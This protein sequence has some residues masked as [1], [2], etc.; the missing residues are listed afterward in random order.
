MSNSE[1]VLETKECFRTNS[2]IHPLVGFLCRFG[3]V[4]GRSDLK[5]MACPP[6]SPLPPSGIHNRSSP[7]DLLR[8]HHFNLARQLRPSL[9]P[10]CNWLG[11]DDVR[12]VGGQPFSAGGFS[13]LW[14][15]TLDTR[16]V[17]I[18]SYRRYLFFDLSQVFLVC[19]PSPSP[20]R[21]H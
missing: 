9:S 19:L 4:T 12:I 5:Q 3:C 2:H 20:R 13:D 11:E 16:Q 14:R 15:G 6:S 18:K 7:D 21:S 10:I 1:E 17:A 8:Q